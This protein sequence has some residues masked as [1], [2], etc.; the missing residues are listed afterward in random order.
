MLR[1]FLSINVLIEKVEKREM[2]MYI[3]GHISY[4]LEPVLLGEDTLI[5]AILNVLQLLFRIIS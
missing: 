1:T 5:T 3:L 2:H 4:F